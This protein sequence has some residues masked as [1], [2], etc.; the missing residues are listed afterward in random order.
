MTNGTISDLKDQKILLT[1]GRV[2]WLTDHGVEV[3]GLVKNRNG[4]WVVIPDDNG[5]KPAQSNASYHV[6][7][8]SNK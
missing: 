8:L 2:I 5:F 1:E 6:N 3:K 7:N 4:I